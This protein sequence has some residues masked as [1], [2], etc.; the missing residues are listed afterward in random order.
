MD[1]F[2]KFFHHLNATLSLSPIH[3][4]TRK[5]GGSQNFNNDPFFY[6]L[7]YLEKYLTDFKTVFTN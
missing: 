3:L 7:A 2:Q 4:V 6:A 5:N 1:R